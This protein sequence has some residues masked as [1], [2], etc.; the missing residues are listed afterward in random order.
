MAHR[1]HV[2][3][4]KYYA[5][6]WGKKPYEVARGREYD[7]HWLLA[8]HLENRGIVELVGGYDPPLVVDVTP[9]EDGDGNH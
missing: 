1:I 8:R 9:E 5:S 4:L 2:R 7:M 6:E 3:A